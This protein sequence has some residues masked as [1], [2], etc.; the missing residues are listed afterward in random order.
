MIRPEDRAKANPSWRT[1]TS[2]SSASAN[3]M[4]QDLS[5]PAGTYTL[6]IASPDGTQTLVH[7]VLGEAVRWWQATGYA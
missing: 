5:L 1:A 4:E 2:S 7:R 6:V 3:Q